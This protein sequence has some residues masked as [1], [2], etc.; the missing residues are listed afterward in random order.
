MRFIPAR[1]GKLLG[2]RKCKRRQQIL[3]LLSMVNQ[4]EH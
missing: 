4:L 1:A 3:K 2:L